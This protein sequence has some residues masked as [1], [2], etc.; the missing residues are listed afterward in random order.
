M[1]HG[2]GESVVDALYHPGSPVPSVRAPGTIIVLNGPSSAGKT[3][4]AQA[5]QESARLPFLCFG[6]DTLLAVLPAR[7]KRSEDGFHDEPIPGSTPSEIMWTSG[8]AGDLA[9]S[10]MHAAIAALS[11]AGQNVIV[12]HVLA[13]DRWLRDF[14]CQF[15]YLPVLYVGVR[16]PISV[17]MERRLQRGDRDV[18][19][20]GRAFARWWE[21]ATHSIGIYDL[22]IDTSELC[23]DQCAEIIRG[24]IDSGEPGKAVQRLA[25]HLGISDVGFRPSSCWSFESSG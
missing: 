19:H 2:D 10:G 9:I 14:V 15:R 20:R 5:F 3:S 1:V 23:P 4:I 16:C 21:R 12:D 13:H 25:E 7:M 22:E 17:I 18:S 24:Y 8:E 6:I 11:R